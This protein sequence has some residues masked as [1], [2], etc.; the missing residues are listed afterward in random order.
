M[1]CTLD[2]NNGPWPPHAR[3]PQPPADPTPEP[4]PS[5]LVMLPW[6]RDRS[7]ANVEASASRRER[8][9]RRRRRDLE[10]VAHGAT[11]SEDSGDRS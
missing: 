5:A 7:A 11:P 3:R 1:A 10:V 6:L 9:E 4:L 8:A 2:P